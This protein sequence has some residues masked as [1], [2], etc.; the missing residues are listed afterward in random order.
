MLLNFSLIKFTDELFKE[1]LKQAMI[2]SSLESE[3]SKI[4]A[5]EK[6][7]KPHK[8]IVMS[9]GDF[10]KNYH[11]G[12]HH[13]QSM[14]NYKKLQ[15]FLLLMACSKNKQESEVTVRLI[16]RMKSL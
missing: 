6:Q 3:R 16:L 13:N 4:Q 5:K 2:E 1:H 15:A 7:V 8:P 14:N 12:T 11:E 10:Q 9:L